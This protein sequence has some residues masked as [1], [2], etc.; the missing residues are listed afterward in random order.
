MVRPTDDPKT[1][2][3]ALRLTPRQVRAIDD[4]R[5]ATRPV[6]SRVELVRLA[7]DS[8][9]GLQAEEGQRA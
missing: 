5:A 8:Y 3:V 2:R 1:E 9:L 6:P 4:R 7:I